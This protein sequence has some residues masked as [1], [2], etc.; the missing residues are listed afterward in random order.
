[1]RELDLIEIINKTL[2]DNKHLGDDCAYLKDLEIAV[3]QDSLVENV[4]FSTKFSTPY[5]IGYKSL[6]VNISDILAS[7]AEPKY[8]T[9]SLSLPKNINDDFIKE[10]YTACNDVAKEFGIEIVGGDITGSDKIYISVCAIGS[11][12]GRNISSRANDSLFLM[13]ILFLP[14]NL[15]PFIILKS[16]KILL[17]TSN[18]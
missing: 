9:I 15:L 7:G 6:I 14:M 11:T 18:K 17:L 2:D 5:E 8:I 13:I 3:T 12:K 4:H 10:F 1:M 16:S